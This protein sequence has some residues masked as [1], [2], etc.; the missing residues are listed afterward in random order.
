MT[1]KPLFCQESLDHR[2]LNQLFKRLLAEKRKTERYR[3]RLSGRYLPNLRREIEKGIKEGE[4]KAVVS[5]N[6]LELGIDIGQ[7]DAC[8]MAGYPGSISSTWQQAGRAGR[9]SNTS[10]AILVASSNPLDQFVVNHC[11]YFFG[12]SP[13]SVVID[14]NNLSISMN[15][16]RCASFE[17]PF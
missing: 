8:I 2:G 5:T 17:L 14:P 7:L 10:V 11:N 4:I 13:E 3:Q 12:E 1:C 15:H 9:R 16:I 6:A